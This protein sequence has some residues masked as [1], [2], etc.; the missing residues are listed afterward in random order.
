MARNKLFDEYLIECKSRKEWCGLGNPDSHILIVGKEPY[1]ENLVEDTE[2]IRKLLQEDYDICE[3]H[4][5]GTGVRKKNPTWNNYQ[6]IIE[7]VFLHKDFNPNVYS[8]EECAFTTELNTMFRPQ[9]QL[10][11]KTV[12]NIN[13]RLFFFK[14]SEFIN[15]F[16]VILLACGNFISNDEERGFLIN[17][18]FDV[19][20]DVE[21]DSKGKLK[22]EHKD[23]YKSGHWFYTHHRKK[24]GKRLVIHTRQ[25]SNLFDYRILDDMADI[26]REHLIKLGINID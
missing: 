17:N 1:K 20:F 19:E 23:G 8:F 5:F 26:I 3:N 4:I 21:P 12:K 13:E 25:L 14:E 2:E 6:K 18:T 7:K 10:D 16:P 15:S 11:E 24:D 9:A 22:G